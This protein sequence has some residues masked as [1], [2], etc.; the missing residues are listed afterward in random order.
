M[1]SFGVAAKKLLSTVSLR[2]SLDLYWI[3]GMRRA[4]LRR[5]AQSVAEPPGP[6]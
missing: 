4:A 6:E 2:L 3:S 5:F 1:A